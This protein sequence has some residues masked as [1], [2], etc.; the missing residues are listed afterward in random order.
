MSRIAHGRL[1][2][3][4]K[5]VRWVVLVTSC[6]AMFAAVASAQSVEVVFT[7][8]VVQQA[9]AL[10]SALK[11]EKMTAFDAL[12]LMGGTAERAKAYAD[13][14]AGVTA[15]IV[16]GEAALQ[17]A[18]AV[19]FSALII[20]V[21]AAGAWA[22]VVAR[23]ADAAPCGL[24][25]LRRSAATIATSGDGGYGSPAKFGGQLCE[26]RVRRRQQVAK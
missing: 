1:E 3:L 25:P 6:A 26:G 16:I 19:Q 20:L 14:V 8:A 22:D 12:A 2:E 11:V 7:P 13:R 4:A 5:A 24:V 17:A 15:V 21:N 9:I 23:R 10:K 18:A